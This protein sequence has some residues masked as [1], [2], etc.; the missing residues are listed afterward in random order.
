MASRAGTAVIVVAL[1]CLNAGCDTG[2]PSSNVHTAPGSTTPPSQNLTRGCLDGFNPDVD[3]FPDKTTLGSAAMF[4]VEY[5]HS[6]KV[7][8]VKETYPGG[9]AEHYVLVQCGTAVPAAPDGFADAQVITVPITSLFSSSTT[10][11]PLLV[12]LNRLDVLAGVSKFDA[13][14]SPSVLDRIKTG[15]VEEFSVTASIDAERVAARRPSMLMTGGSNSAA[16][17]IIRA[18]GVPVVA[19]VEYLEKTALG[20]AEWVKYMALFLN[21]ERAADV[22]FDGV[23]ARYLSLVQQTRAIPDTE[24]PAVMTGHASRGMFTI[25]GG[26]SYVASLIRDAGAR[27]VWADDTSNA[28]STVDLESQLRR[29]ADAPF[30]INGGGWASRADMLSDEP[31]YAQFAAYRSGQV[32]VYERLLNAA[33]G[34]DYWSRSV[35]RPDLLLADLVKI[36]HPALVP[37][38]SFEWYLQVPAQ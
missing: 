14:V 9:P 7:V 37:D 20:R 15:G 36:F 33:G 29:A 26:R 13:I 2:A 30:W 12:D 1:A 6:Y 10:H 5:H 35:T 8:T 34:N 25:A 21:E 11:L 22:V 28:S 16:F 27:Y 31:R 32:W 23:K 18:A 24:R 4:S 19:D 17:S 38:H 3:Y